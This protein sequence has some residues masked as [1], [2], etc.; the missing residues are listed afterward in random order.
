MSDHNP[1]RGNSSRKALTS[2]EGDDEFSAFSVSPLA[3]KPPVEIKE[4][5]TGRPEDTPVS[6]SV[7]RFFRKIFG[8]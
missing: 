3:R 1:P 5:S 8:D 2:I 7:V 4:D 6:F